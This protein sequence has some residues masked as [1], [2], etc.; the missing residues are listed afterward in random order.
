M[1]IDD[2]CFGRRHVNGRADNEKIEQNETDS[3]VDARPE[4]SSFPFNCC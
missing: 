4:F 3:D 1:L 2:N